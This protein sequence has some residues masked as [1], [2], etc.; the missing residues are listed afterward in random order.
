MARKKK[1][2]SGGGGGAPGW[3]C[4]FS[5]LMNLLLCFFVLLFSM[6]TVD[7]EKF[8]ELAASLKASYS[9]FDGGAASLSEGNLI[10]SGISQLNDLNDYYNNMGTNPDESEDTNIEDMEE[11]E[12]QREE[13]M[14]Q[15]S[16]E[17]GE[18]LQGDLEA[19]GLFEEGS[20][21]IEITAQYVMLNLNGTLLFDSSSAEIKDSS[22]EFM[23]K[24]GT[25]LKRYGEHQIE[26]IGHTDSRPMSG[27]GIYKNNMMLSQ[28]RA[29]A[30][31]EYLV[32]NKDMDASTLK[33]TGRGEYEPIATNTTAEGRAQNRR[34]EIRIYNSYAAVSNE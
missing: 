34:V 3:M 31:F 12:E 16:E 20:V 2:E 33:C 19:E 21:E 30:V 1:E 10:S 11:Y 27:N 9:I 5:D 23:D 4:T 24:L 17:I 29:Y 26:I 22:E 7:A 13:N 14:I 28:G 8:E 32:N 18:E 15:E 6:S 25:V